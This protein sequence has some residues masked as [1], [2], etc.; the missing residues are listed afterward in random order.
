MPEL[1]EVQTVIN[2]L[3]KNIIKK[4]INKIDIFYDKLLKNSDI[5]EFKK[6]LLNEIIISIDRKGK[7]IIINLTNNKHLVIHLRMEG[8]LF[9]EE[10]N[11]KPSH[12]QLLAEFKLSNGLLRYY[13]TRK[14][15]TFYILKSE[16]LSNFLPLIKL[17]PD[18][19]DKTLDPQSTFK[20]I[21]DRNIAIKTLL[22]DQSIIAGIGNIYANEILFK[23][24]IIPTKKGKEI[25]LIEWK[26]ILNASEEIL[27]QSIKNNGTTIHSFKFNAF[28]SGGYQKFLMV[29]G[30]KNELCKICRN[31]IIYQKINGRGTFYCK[32][33]Q[34]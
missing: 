29:H 25:S 13:D 32:K 19:N 22:L 11:S 4:C 14:F 24:N 18:A 30:R 10:F 23:V 5:D 17:G 26:N 20:F 28:S 33:C 27:N 15:G 6:F 3:K 7:F 21:K 34:K 8:K 9:F 31:P 1:P 2:Y 12:P 16:N